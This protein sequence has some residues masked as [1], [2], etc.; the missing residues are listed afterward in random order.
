MRINLYHS[1]QIK[2]VQRLL[3]TSLL[4][5]LFRMVEACSVCGTDYTDE[6][7]KAYTFITFLLILL[8]IGS[9]AFLGIWI[10]RKYWNYDNENN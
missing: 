3:L 1:K 7:I 9:F 4:V 8:P 5:M 6:E 2:N 10:G